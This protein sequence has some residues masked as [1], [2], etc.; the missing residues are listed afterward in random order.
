MD[1]ILI[2]SILVLFFG[3]VFFLVLSFT[4]YRKSYYYKKARAEMEGSSIS[5]GILS[6]I[7][8]FSIALGMIFLLF[9]ADEWIFA[10][11]D[12]TFVFLILAN[13]LLVTL[14]S[15]FDAVFIDIFILLK[16]RPA[17]L[18]LPEGQPTSSHMKQHV[19]R[20]FTYGWL[21]KIPFILLASFL[22]FTLDI[23]F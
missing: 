6:R 1:A 21:F 3:M 5:P 11:L 18:N 4:I 9:L 19:R 16:W 23:G 13:T 22:S 7:V 10:G 8:T 2:R 20:Q 12:P 17:F 14:L 15:T